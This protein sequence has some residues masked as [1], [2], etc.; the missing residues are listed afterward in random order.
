MCRPNTSNLGYGIVRSPAVNLLARL[1]FA[2]R[3]PAF[4]NHIL[5]QGSRDEI[6]AAARGIDQ[7][8]QHRTP[9]GAAAGDGDP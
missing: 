9:A 5:Q 4:N 6:F 8:L 2:L 3:Q 1:A 7:M